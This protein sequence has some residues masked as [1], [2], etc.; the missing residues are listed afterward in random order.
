MQKNTK[1]QTW[2][3]QAKTDHSGLIGS[4]SSAARPQPLAQ[5]LLPRS[6]DLSLSFEIKYR[7]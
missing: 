4:L 2:L 5:V 7:R 3:S 6:L 1:S